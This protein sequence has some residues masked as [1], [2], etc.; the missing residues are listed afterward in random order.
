MRSRPMIARR[1]FLEL[2]G[3]ATAWPLIA[4]AQAPENTVIGL[5][6]ASYAGAEPHLA[7][8]I[9]RGLQQVGFVEGQNLTIEFPLCGH[10]IRSV[11]GA[12]RGTGRAPGRGDHL[13]RQSGRTG[14]EEG[15]CE[16]S[17][18]L[19][20]RGRTGRRW[21]A[22]WPQPAG[23]QRHRLR[24]FFRLVGIE[25]AQPAARNRAPNLR[26]SRSCSI[27]TRHSMRASAKRRTGAARAL[28]LKLLL[29]PAGNDREIEA[30]F[31]A[32]DKQKSSALL[33]SASPFFTW[34]RRG[35]IV[36]LAA[37]TSIPAIYSLREWVMAGGL[38][39]YGPD[40]QETYRLVGVYTGKIL[41]GVRPDD[42]PVE[43]LSHF[44]LA[45]NTGTARTLG[46]DVPARLLA[47]ADTVIA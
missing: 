27:P 25:T 12:R 38:M 18:H 24:V 9:R 26:P 45:I 22:Q 43:H 29:L 30:A 17:D 13:Q 33:V 1:R 3:A 23:Q 44:E 11:A 6:S 19:Q 21:I 35:Q 7:D 8:A 31:K 28:G 39:S 41:K 47:L 37:R 16:H 34:D 32:M 10:Q 4:N 40:L 20:H 2:A 46:L 42:L 5:L 15:D 14:G 36:D